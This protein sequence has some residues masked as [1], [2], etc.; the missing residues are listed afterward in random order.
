[1]APM[2]AASCGF[3]M[4]VMPVMWA[5]EDRLGTRADDGRLRSNGMNALGAEVEARRM[6]DWSHCN[7]FL[8]THK[9]PLGTLTFFG[10]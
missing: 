9:R 4:D 5:A 1:M 7:N 3:T 2:L 6:D 8:G 10:R